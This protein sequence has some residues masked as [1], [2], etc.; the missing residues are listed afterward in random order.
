MKTI[1]I[2]R[3]R[4]R[5][6]SIYDWIE[7]RGL[8]AFVEPMLDIQPKSATLPLVGD[9]GGLVFTSA[10]AARLFPTLTN[11]QDWLD[12][13][14][15]CVGLQTEQA[16]LA[17]GFR[18]TLCAD[19]DAV[20][21]QAL[22]NLQARGK[23]LHIAGED[24]A[25]TLYQNNQALDKIV[26]YKAEL[27]PSLSEDLQKRL[28]NHSIGP[29]LFFSARSA[30]NFAKLVK[31]QGYASACA[32]ITALCLGA[33]VA[34]AAQAN[35]WKLVK[36]AQKPT[37]RSFQD[38]LEQEIEMTQD[39]QNGSN[40]APKAPSAADR[41]ATSDRRQR[42]TKP[43]ANGIIHSPNYTGPERRSGIDRR[44]EQQRQRALKIRAEKMRFVKR[45]AITTVSI[46]S[47]I[48][49]LGMILLLPEYKEMQERAKAAA[50]MEQELSAV[51]QRLE[52]LRKK[53]ARSFSG[54]LNSGIERIEGVVEKAQETGSSV[55]VSV[56]SNAL[57][58]Q[59]SPNGHSAWQM[60]MGYLRN[61]I[62]S[63]AGIDPAQAIAA[64]RAQDPTLNAI[65]QGVNQNNLAAAAMLMTLTEFRQAIG[66]GEPFEQDLA[67]LRRLAGRDPE[68][69]AALTQLEPYAQTGIMSP[70]HLAGEFKDLAGDIVMAKF[71]GEDL[72]TGQAALGRLDDLIKV[73][74]TDDLSSNS[75][76]AIVARA[77]Q[78]IQSGDISGAVRELSQ[79][80]AG[81]AKVAQPWID[82]ANKQIHTVA[83]SNDLIGT[84]VSR[85]SAQT[86]DISIEGLASFVTNALQSG[87]QDLDIPRNI[88]NAFP[89]NMNQQ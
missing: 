1:L 23:L 83:R 11:H 65:L 22:I 85:V 82:M 5:A 31:A 41:R 37:L 13:P 29:V 57:N 64:A 87:P 10:E 52:D 40:N 47:V 48:A 72:P 18:K 70:T 8:D 68:L 2:T 62:L 69:L 32:D 56:L 9:Y 45:T 7:S 25:A 39:S 30:A 28:L 66:R 81:P 74:R 19:G 20:D 4:H 54:R 16:A 53:Q 49:V 35:G 24:I 14:V 38:L 44:A 43:D 60:A 3:P 71:K 61:A 79:L 26:V 33:G 50:L 78:R 55:M 58:L 12:L 6:G 76:D 15:F 51:N 84:V 63:H 34:K 17:A 88:R 27:T 21:L 46:F 75:T 42:E 86:G 89:M 36:T 80:E 77:Q 73:R 59:N 67:V